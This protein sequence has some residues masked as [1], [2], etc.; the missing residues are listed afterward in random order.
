MEEGERP[1]LVGNLLEG[2]IYTNGN[3]KSIKLYC[4]PL[5]ILYLS[6]RYLCQSKQRIQIINKNKIG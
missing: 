3:S 6:L 1:W 5:S 4:K 2:E